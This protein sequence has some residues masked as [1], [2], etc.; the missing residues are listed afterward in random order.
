MPWHTA[1]EKKMRNFKCKQFVS[2]LVLRRLQH[3][4]KK[5]TV[6]SEIPSAYITSWLNLWLSVCVCEFCLHSHNLASFHVK[7]SDLGCIYNRNQISETKRVLAHES[8]WA[9]CICSGKG[10]NLSTAMQAS[11]KQRLR[12]EAPGPLCHFGEK[13][14]CVRFSGLG[15]GVSWGELHI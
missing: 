2:H 4:S 9:V 3:L 6:L 5:P 15:E 1:G 10:L 14:W 12:P 13:T 11:S 8:K 7:R